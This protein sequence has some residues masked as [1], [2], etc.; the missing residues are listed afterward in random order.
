MKKLGKAER[1]RKH[2]EE[3]RVCRSFFL[4]IGDGKA[5][6]Q[7]HIEVR[8]CVQEGNIT[9]DRERRKEGRTATRIAGNKKAKEVRTKARTK[10]QQTLERNKN[11]YKQMQ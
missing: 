2:G 11:G 4:E 10:R 3:G 7:E 1:R 9:K 6:E 5:K 8:K